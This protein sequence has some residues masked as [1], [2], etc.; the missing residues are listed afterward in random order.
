[1]HGVPVGAA[2]Y[3]YPGLR[4]VKVLQAKTSQIVSSQGMDCDQR[5]HEPCSGVRCGVEHARKP[6]GGQRRR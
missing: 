3:L 2:A 6:I 1:M 5:D 4:W